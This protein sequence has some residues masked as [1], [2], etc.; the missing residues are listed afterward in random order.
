M[1]VEIMPLAR[2]VPGGKTKVLMS[3]GGRDSFQFV[4]WLRLALYQAMHHTKTNHIYLDTYGLM[5]VPG[6]QLV[7]NITTANGAFE[8]GA[9]TLDL[10]NGQQTVAPGADKRLQGARGGSI[11]T[12][13]SARWNERYMQAMREARLMLFV[14]TPAWLASDYCKLEFTQFT[15]EWKVRRGTGA[16]KGLDALALTFADDPVSPG[17]YAEFLKSSG[18][19]GWSDI[20]VLRLSRQWA[21]QGPAR[22]SLSPNMRDLYTLT[23]ESFRQL[24]AWMPRKRSAD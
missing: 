7:L 3:F 18:L 15:N 12:M 20:Q 23:D 1:T 16:A 5:D 19:T 14:V 4:C 8:R 9:V 21:V 22:A 2:L 11:G 6:S 17:R 13:N 24:V 10:A